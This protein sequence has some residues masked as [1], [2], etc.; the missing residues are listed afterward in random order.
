MDITAVQDFFPKL[1]QFGFQGFHTLALGLNMIPPKLP[2]LLSEH[3]EKRRRGREHQATS[4]RAWGP[5]LAPTTPRREIQLW[6]AP[7]PAPHSLPAPRNPHHRSVL[8]QGSPGAASAIKGGS[9]AMRV[10]NHSWGFV[11]SLLLTDSLLS[12]PQPT[13]APA[14]DVW[15]DFAKASG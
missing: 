6:R 1:N 3:E 4:C 14:A 2:A 12:W 10:G 7:G 9:V 13:A 5:Q 15:G 11:F 8:T